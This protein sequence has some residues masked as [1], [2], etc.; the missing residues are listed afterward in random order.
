MGSTV[1]S[2]SKV[3]SWEVVALKERAERADLHQQEHLI[4]QNGGDPMLAAQTQTLAIIWVVIP[5][6]AA[7]LVA[8]GIAA[9]V[10]VFGKKAKKARVA[11]LGPRMAG[12]STLGEYLES[13]TITKE[14]LETRG[15]EIHEA[16]LRMEDLELRVTISSPGGD[17]DQY[18]VWLDA[19]RQAHVIVLMIDLARLQDPPYVDEVLHAARHIQNWRQSGDIGDEVA[20]LVVGTHRDQIPESGAVA[21]ERSTLAL[22]VLKEVKR[23]LQP[24][25]TLLLSLYETEGQ[26]LALFEIAS[27]AGKR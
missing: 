5:I 1:A 22:P 18:G 21:W 19:A 23:R 9:A 25:K 10:M 11:L 26:H 3:S 17:R 6:V 14:Y 27:A 7:V 8:G 4:I 20:L 2:P 12:K 16:R 24:S 13:G 15:I